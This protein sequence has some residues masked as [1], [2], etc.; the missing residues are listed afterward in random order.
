MIYRNLGGTGLKV[1]EIG[2]GCE[3]FLEKDGA[4]TERMFARA[5]EGGVNVMDLYSPDPDMHVRV[6]RAV[7]GRRKDFVYQA[8]LCTVW[9]NGQYKATRRMDEVVPSFEKMLKNLGTDYIDVGMIHYV[10]SAATWKQVTEGGVAEYARK[11]KKEGKIRHIGMSS[12][13]PVVALE[14]VKSG[15][16]EVLMFSVNPCYDLLPGDEDVDKLFAEESYEKPLF[17]LDPVREEL[18]ETCQR[19][20][21]GITVM[22]VYGGGDLLTDSSPAGKALTPAQCI[23]YALTRPAVSS[24]MIGVHSEKELADALAYESASVA[25]KD[26]AS[27]FATFPKISW[28]GHCMYCGHCAPCPKGIDVASVTKFLNLSKAQGSV[29][30]T[31]REHYAALSAKAGDCI[32]CGACEKRCPFGVK[33]I[34][35]M[36]EAKRIFGA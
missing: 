8:H 30:E 32:A 6:G 31:V 2:L 7:G 5:F 22:K 33:V 16:V 23:H 24:V 9:Q 19:L 17:N 12:H 3:G 28:K 10:D 11:L 13:N 36:R 15:L 35:N 4:F 1:S 29:P 26:Y 27:V 14:A 25:E 21:V 34:E 18:Y 20:G